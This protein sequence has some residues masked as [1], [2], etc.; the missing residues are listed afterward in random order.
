MKKIWRN[1]INKTPPKKPDLGRNFGK[2][3]LIDIILLKSN[4]LIYKKKELLIN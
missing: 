2:I 1:S 4:R 3:N